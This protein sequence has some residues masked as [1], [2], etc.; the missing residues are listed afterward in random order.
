MVVLAE[1]KR[2][3]GEV[4]QVR[5]GRPIPSNIGRVFPGWG[6]VD[7]VQTLEY[8]G[9]VGPELPNFLGGRWRLFQ[10]HEFDQIAPTD[11][12]QYQVIC[13]TLSIGHMVSDDIFLCPVPKDG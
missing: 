5:L 8:T 1:S 7:V 4:E 10:L 9:E 2:A 6:L 13:L 11:K 12:I 3:R